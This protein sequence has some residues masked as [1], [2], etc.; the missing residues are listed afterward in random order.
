MKDQLFMSPN[1]AEVCVGVPLFRSQSYVC[2]APGVENYGIA[3]SVEPSKPLAYV[4]DC[5][6]FAQVLSA[7]WVEKNL[8]NLGD[9]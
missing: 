8:I 9:L 3:I 5:G 4:L 2:E 6:G 7:E 1:N